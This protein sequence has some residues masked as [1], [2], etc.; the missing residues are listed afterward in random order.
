MSLRVPRILSLRSVPIL[1]AALFALHCAR[2]VP[3][4]PDGVLVISMEQQASWVRNF[5]P[6]TPA[7]SPRWPTLAG[8]YE[9]LYV[10]NSVTA[11]MVPW[12]AID[13][14]W[15][16]EN[17]VLRITSREGVEWSDGRPF[18]AADIAF[19]FSLLRDN[20]GLDRRRLWDFLADVTLVDER[21][22]DFAFQRVYIPGG[23]D[24]LAQ[25]IVPEHVW[26][27]VEDPIA[28]TNE[29]P[30]AT[31]PFTEV[32]F[33]RN[34]VW[35]LGKNPNYWQEGLPKVEALR[36]PAYSSN[37]RA[38]MALIFDEVDW[39]ANF[40]PAIDRAYVARDPEFHEYWFPLTGTTV[41]LYANTARAPFDRVD[42]RKALS[43]AIDRELLVDVAAYRYSRP[44]DGTAL[45]DAYVAWHNEEIGASAE[46]MKHD[47]AR[48]NELLDAAGFARGEDGIRLLPDGSPWEYQVICVSGWSDWVRASQVIARALRE[49]GIDASVKLFDFGA[50]FQ[51]VQKGEFD[52]SIGWSFEGPTPY[53]FYKWLMSSDTVKPEGA[54]SHGNWHRF[55]SADADAALAAFEVAA[56]PDEQR[57]LSDAMQRTFVQEVP[58][59]PLYPNP[60]WAEYNTS[61]FTGFPSAED[62]YADPS[63]NKFDRGEVL[64]VL[65][66]L[67]PRQE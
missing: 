66:Q 50:W 12:L 46:W 42:V 62:P 57:R 64:L 19:T 20:E 7:T 29:D 10:F 4:A 24:V 40:I 47:P 55:A 35:E 51:K 67:K 15:R 54:T 26:S 31:G 53:E 13:Y 17:R 56:D 48:A 34:Q 25:Q 44:C 58:A 36:F 43:M 27:Q 61:R 21:T 14:E 49:V 38:N 8:I 28:F 1:L 23:F 60:S 16:E 32:R 63:P 2:D 33:F 45:S 39:A 3:R 41:F 37:D 18:T 9:P 52:L 65:T 6:L 30:V 5:N 22:V 59:I 11:E